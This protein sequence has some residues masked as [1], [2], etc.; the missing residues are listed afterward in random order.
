LANLT[1][2]SNAGH[3]GAFLDL[4]IGSA[5]VSSAGRDSRIGWDFG[6]PIELGETTHDPVVGS[7]L[8]STWNDLA[9]MSQASLMRWYDR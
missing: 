4:L 7:Y 6:N 8:C 3:S 1:P 9:V 5:V 2:E